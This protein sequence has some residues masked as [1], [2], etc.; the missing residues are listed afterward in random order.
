ME[1]FRRI[2]MKAAPFKGGLFARLLT[3]CVV[4]C[5]TGAAIVTMT[6]YSY[7]AALTENRLVAELS[8]LAS[9][10][11]PLV[12]D[13]LAANDVQGATG[14]LHVFGGLQYVTCVDLSRDGLLLASWPT[15]GCDGGQ[16]RGIEQR[17]A[18]PLARGEKLDYRIRVDD[19]LLM[20]PVRREAAIVAGFMMLSAL[21]VSISLALSFRRFVLVP[22]DGLRQA[23]L[24]STPRRPVRAKQIRDDEIGA[25]VKAYNSLVAAARLFVRRLDRSQTQLADSEKRCRDLAEVSGDWFF[26]MD[27]DLRLSFVSD[28][29]FEITGLDR[30]GVIGRRRQ[31]IASVSGGEDAFARHL[32]DLAARREFRRFEY[33]LKGG[34][35]RSCHI[36]LSGVPVFDDGGVF[37]GYRG[38]GQDI[39]DIREKERLLAE[40]NRNFGDSVTYAS[41]IQRGLLPTAEQLGHHLGRTRIIWQPKDLVGGD[42]YW[43]RR[44]GDSDYLVFFDCTGHGVPGAFMT[45]IVTSVLDQIAVSAAT[46]LPAARILQRLHDGVCRQLGITTDSPGHD[47][48]DCAVVRLD[49]G[50]DT[51]EFAG[52]SIDLFEID[53]EGGVTCHRGSRLTLGYRHLPGQLDPRPVSRRIGDSAFLMSTDGLLTQVGEATGRVLGTRRFQAALAAVGD[54]EPGRLV[55]A[56]GRL[57]KQW[58]GREERRDDV[59]VIAFR[60]HDPVG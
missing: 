20:V 33:E 43:V 27:S 40:T 1:G 9:A 26:E 58:Q 16:N 23:M 17:V 41:S 8:A 31:D 54:N 11:A 55:R 47:G 60:P 32:A 52:A 49:R 30:A 44:I 24:D 38:T 25:I 37:L 39:S 34:D 10:T 22:L 5:V 57:L 51:M 59:A 36:S 19:A 15:D 7:R 21:I 29:F 12:A 18:L 46:A 35:G 6:F 45:L 56:A 50:A 42:F 2:K 4:V 3:L 28:R 48:L 53:A 13:R 14:F